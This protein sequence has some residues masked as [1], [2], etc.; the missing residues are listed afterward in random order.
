[1]VFVHPRY[2]SFLFV[3][4]EN[5][6][7]FLLDLVV[8]HLPGPSIFPKE[9]LDPKAESWA[10]GCL[11]RYLETRVGFLSVSLQTHG[12]SGYPQDAAIQKSPQTEYPQ[13]KSNICICFAFKF[14]HLPARIGWE[15]LL[16]TPHATMAQILLLVHVGNPICCWWCPC[17]GFCFTRFRLSPHPPEA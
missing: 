5:R 2:V 10:Y 17:S 4:V 8:T 7:R 12:K 13:D 14:V 6:W 16:P 3:L 1:M 11:S 15:W 9:H